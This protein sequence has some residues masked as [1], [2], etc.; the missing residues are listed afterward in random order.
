M[1]E[2]TSCNFCTLQWLRKNA[3]A[4]KKQVILRD[5]TGI[6]KGVHVYVVPEGVEVPEVIVSHDADGPGDE[7]HEQYFTSWFMALTDKCAC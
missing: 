3:V 2:R 5:G 4:E 1:S 7:F 6:L